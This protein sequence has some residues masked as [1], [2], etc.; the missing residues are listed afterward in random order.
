MPRNLKFGSL[1]LAVA[2]TGC[3]FDANYGNGGFQCSNGACPSGLV[4]D[5]AANK[6]VATL[7]DAA[8]DVPSD[9][10]VDA[11][12]DGE[13][14]HALTCADPGPIAS[15]GGTASGTTAGRGFTIYGM[16]GGFVMNG[17]DAVY[18]LPSVAASSQ[19]LVSITG[20]K[21]YVIAPCVTTPSTTPCIG[22]VYASAGNPIQV[23]APTAGDYYVIVDDITP[24][25]TGAYTVTV[26]K[27]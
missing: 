9:T 5:T 8:L 11:M 10:S 17:A 4:C 25:D 15:T 20:R 14:S 6:C 19:Y 16:C 3:F 26:T 23:M 2:G 1:I 24:S 13:V 12:P 21:A 7:V 27:Q 18:K 22:N